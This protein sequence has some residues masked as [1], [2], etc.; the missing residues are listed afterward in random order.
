MTTAVPVEGLVRPFVAGNVSPQSVRLPAKPN[1][2]L[3]V[4]CS[5]GGSGGRTT[6]FTMSGSGF[7]VEN[8]NNQYKESNRKSTLVHVENEDNPD[9]F[10]EFCRA[11]NIQFTQRKE[12]QRQQKNSTYDP[13]NAAQAQARLGKERSKQGYGYQYPEDKTCRPKNPDKGGNC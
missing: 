6:T 1:N 3:V 7:I 8:T 2:P 11:D 12:P 13:Y 10:V 9:Q 5:L 4:E